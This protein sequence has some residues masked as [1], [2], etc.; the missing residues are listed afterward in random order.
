MR[1]FTVLDAMRR[2]RE[3]TDDVGM[4][5]VILFDRF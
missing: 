5:E 1:V 2:R 3:G 4:K